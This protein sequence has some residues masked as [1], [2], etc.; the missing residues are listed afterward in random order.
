[1]LAQRAAEAF[2]GH[3]RV[4]RGDDDVMLIEIWKEQNG[5]CFRYDSPYETT[6]LL[7]PYADLLRKSELA[8]RGFLEQYMVDVVVEFS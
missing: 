4:R 1:M 5:R 8:A 6:Q 3:R 2:F 7:A